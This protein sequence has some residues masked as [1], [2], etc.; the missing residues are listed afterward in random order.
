MVD[1]IPSVCG[2][3]IDIRVNITALM[4]EIGFLLRNLGLDKQFEFKA[5]KSTDYIEGRSA[6]ILVN[7]KVYG[8]FGEVSP[9]ILSN[10]EIGHPA[11]AFELRLPRNT[12]WTT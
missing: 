1:Q 8:T 9:D 12:D 4:T 2:L 3:A 6:D 7:G 11:V 5:T 10:F